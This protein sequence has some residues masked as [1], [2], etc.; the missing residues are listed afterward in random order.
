MNNG[1]GVFRHAPVENNAVGII[2]VA[3]GIIVASANA[4]AAAS[5]F[6]MVDKRLLGFI[7]Y[8]GLLCA[9]PDARFT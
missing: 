1:L 2:G 5:A 7:E 6:L 3:Y 9:V 8:N 4:A